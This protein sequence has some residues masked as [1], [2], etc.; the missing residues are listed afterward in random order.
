MDLIQHAVKTAYELYF[1]N[2]T[3]RTGTGT[4][5]Q[6]ELLTAEI[7]FKE[8]RSMIVLSE[9]SRFCAEHSVAHH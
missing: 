8:Y 3:E 1:G 2:R 9:Q 4:T 5:V 7:L 6:L